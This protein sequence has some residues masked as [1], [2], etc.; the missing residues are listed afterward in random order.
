MSEQ[1]LKDVSQEEATELAKI[2]DIKYASYLNGRFFV[3]TTGA[4]A[5]FSLAT[6]TLRNTDETFFYPVEGRMESKEQNLSHRE[7][8]LFLIDYIDTYF[9]QFLQEGEDTFVPIDWADFHCEGF[10]FQL[11]GQIFN[12]KIDELADLLLEGDSVAH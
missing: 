5:G 8:C 3:I 1:E 10:S 12:K 11:K 2:M 7:S 4:S 9:E 6:I